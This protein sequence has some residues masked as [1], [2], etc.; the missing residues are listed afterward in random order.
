MTCVLLGGGDRRSEE[1][2]LNI[3]IRVPTKKLMAAPSPFLVIAA[4]Y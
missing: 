3:P 2:G 1:D 4:L